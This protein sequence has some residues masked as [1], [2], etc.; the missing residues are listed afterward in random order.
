M[1]AGA[2]VV[3]PDGQPQGE[4]VLGQLPTQPFSQRLVGITVRPHHFGIFHTEP[5]VNAASP[6]LLGLEEVAGESL[7]EIWAVED[8]S[9]IA[10]HLRTS[11]GLE[12]S[13]ICTMRSIV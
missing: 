7:F 13:C 8:N 12:I 4:A 10:V 3:G 11:L 2:V 6:G 9:E 1:I 5:A